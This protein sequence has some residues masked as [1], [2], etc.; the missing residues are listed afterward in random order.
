MSVTSPEACVAPAAIRGGDGIRQCGG[1]DPDDLRFR[2]MN[3]GVDDSKGH[4]QSRTQQRPHLH[5]DVGMGGVCG[6]R[7]DTTLSEG[8]A[9]GHLPILSHVKQLVMVRAASGKGAKNQKQKGTGSLTTLDIMIDAL[10][11]IAA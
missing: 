4:S 9:D 5:E 6:K 2:A 7:T 8:Q 3:I 10:G 11:T 1:Y